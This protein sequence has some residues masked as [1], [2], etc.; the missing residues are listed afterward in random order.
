M[1]IWFQSSWWWIAFDRSGNCWL[2]GWTNRGEAYFQW[3][4]PLGAVVPNCDIFLS[5]YPLVSFFPVSALCYWYY[6]CILQPC[7]TF[8]C[9]ANSCCTWKAINI[10]QWTSAYLHCWRRMPWE[11]LWTRREM[12]DPGSISSPSTSCDPWETVWV[13]WGV[14]F[15]LIKPHYCSQAQA[16]V[17]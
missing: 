6:P 4:T 17:L 12:R 11:W 16:H 10:W 13:E 15:K 2:N 8:F 7:S 3:S 14:G 9:F 1:L 5:M